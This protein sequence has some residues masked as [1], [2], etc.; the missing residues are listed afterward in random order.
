VFVKDAEPGDMIE[1]EFLDIV[2]QATAFSVHIRRKKAASF[3][4]LRHGSPFT[5]RQTS[6]IDHWPV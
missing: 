1:V 4:V 5:T 6:T 2:P 3:P